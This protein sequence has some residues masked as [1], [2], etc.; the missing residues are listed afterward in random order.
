MTVFAKIDRTTV[1][2]T[3]MEQIIELV[4]TGQLKPGEKLPGEHALVE[5]FGI[6]RSSIREA[7]KALEVLGFIKRSQEGSFVSKDLEMPAFTK[8]LY[9]DI[10]AQHAEIH[11]LYQARQLLETQIGELATAYVTDDDLEEL[12]AMC[13]AMET[14]PDDQVQQHVNLD[15][16]FHCRISELA[17]NPVLTQ[18]WELTFEVLFKIRQRIPFTPQNIRHS[19]ERH[20]LLMTALRERNPTRVRKIISE[21]LEIGEQQLVEMLAKQGS[22]TPNLTSDFTTSRTADVTT[23]LT[24]TPSK[25]LKN[26]QKP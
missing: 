12:Q 9:H 11:H 8:T 3:V 6:G 10:L 21:T 1:A 23:E 26:G 19:D 22:S 7:L 18:L 4:R 20:R 5:H 16:N 13:E 17:G 15:R 2:D 24:N 25:E 14:T